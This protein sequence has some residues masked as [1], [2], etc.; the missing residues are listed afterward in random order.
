MNMPTETKC[1]VAC[2]VDAVD[3]FCGGGGLT[4][5]L[6]QAGVNVKMGVEIDPLC[7]YAYEHNNGGAKF[8]EKSV[9][10]LKADEIRNCFEEGHV[11]LLAGCPPCQT[12]SSYN[13]KAKHQDPRYR[14]PNEF[15]RL[16]RVVMPDMVSLENV[17]LLTKRPIFANLVK[18]MKSLGYNVDWKIVFCPDYGWPQ[19]RKRL[20]LLAS[21]L[22]PIKVPEPTRT[23]PQAVRDSYGWQDIDLDHGFHEVGYLTA[24]DNIRYTISEPARIE[25][26]K[27][28]AALNRQRWE[29]EEAAGLHKKGKK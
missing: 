25:I 23:K 28:L 15:G 24:N 3:L 16:V 11:S 26:L 9:V 22:G 2:A 14:L 21:R 18:E 6:R 4:C 20:V 10:E 5:G 29:E 17:P 13:Q 8:L 7:R 1:Q 12:F 27:R 19:R